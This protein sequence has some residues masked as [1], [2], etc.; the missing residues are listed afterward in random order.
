MEPGRGAHV[1]HISPFLS[2]TRSARVARDGRDFQAERG[3][4][5]VALSG[6]REDTPVPSQGGHHGLCLLAG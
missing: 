3:R 6:T 1:P 5:A 4:R 2:L